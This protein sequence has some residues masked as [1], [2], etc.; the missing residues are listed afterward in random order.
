MTPG[1]KPTHGHA[2]RRLGVSPE[3]KVWEGIRERCH[4]PNSKNYPRYGGR[5]IT[6]CPQWLS[7]FSV[8]LADMGPGHP[9]ST[10]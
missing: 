1:R 10:A 6:V 9:R 3:Y 7:S 5:C 2:S 4:N 8:F